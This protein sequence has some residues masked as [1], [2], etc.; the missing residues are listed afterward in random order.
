MFLIFFIKLFNMDTLDKLLKL[1]KVA[2]LVCVKYDKM[3][4]ALKSALTILILQTALKRL[5]RTKF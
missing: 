2:N 5:I 3:A 4:S 1:E